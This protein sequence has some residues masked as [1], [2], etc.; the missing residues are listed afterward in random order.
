MYA[1][2]S[3]IQV[4]RNMPFLLLWGQRLFAPIFLLYQKTPPLGA[5]TT[6]H[7]ATS[8]SLKGV[9]GQYFVNSEAT[10]DVS[11][12]AADGRLRERLWVMSET[13]CRLTGKNALSSSSSSSPPTSAAARRGKGRKTT[14]P[15]SPT[16]RKTTAATSVKQ[17]KKK[18]AS[19]KRGAAVPAAAVATTPGRRRSS[20]RA[21]IGSVNYKE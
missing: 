13:A 2:V 8:P 19:P 3:F 21:S 15:S 5:Y 11:P 7:V 20:R 10:T 18:A 12:L 6:V 9:G 16:P 4:T 1:S 14:P 17:Q